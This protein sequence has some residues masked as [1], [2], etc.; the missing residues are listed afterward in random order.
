MIADKIRRPNCGLSWWMISLWVGFLL[1][2]AYMGW[3]DRWP[4]HDY[5]GPTTAP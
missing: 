3:S 1:L 5:T 2:T 4:P